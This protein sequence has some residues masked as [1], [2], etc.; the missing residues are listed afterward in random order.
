ML[1]FKNAT[2]GVL[3]ALFLVSPLHAKIS[4]KDSVEKAMIGLGKV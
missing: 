1:N 3:M 4:A 2:Y